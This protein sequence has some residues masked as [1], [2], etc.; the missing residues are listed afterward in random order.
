MQKN[1][2]ILI[3]LALLLSF[4][5]CEDELDKKVGFSVSATSSGATTKGDTLI[6][7]KSEPVTFH[8]EGNPDFISFFSGE[9]GS[10]Y[11]KRNQTE[12]PIDEITSKLN[13]TAFAQ[14]G[15]IPNT[16]SVYLSTTFDGLLGAGNKKADSLR[17]EQNDWIDITAL[18]NLPTASNG[19]SD[20]NIPLNEYLG[21]RLTIAFL[22]HTQQNTLAQPTWEIRNLKIVNTELK[23]GRDSEL[24]ATSMGFSPLD[25]YATNALAYNSGTG[26]GIWGSNTAR[27]RISSSPVGSAMN[28]DWMVSA[29]FTINSRQTDKGVGIKTITDNVLQ[30]Y[31]RTYGTNGIY[32]V[33]FV[34]SNS[35]FEHSAEAVKNL[36]IKVID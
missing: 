11:S 12:I 26:A 5:A 28:K 13:F 9:A 27:L 14:Y 2:L 30:T 33:T 21:K 36:V 35:N 19:T 15:A 20:V 4:S 24:P 8:L 10:E 16:M 23:T 1:I 31:T 22:Y 6:V 34:A 7:S 18:C 25:M 3:S 17:I 29:P 32:V